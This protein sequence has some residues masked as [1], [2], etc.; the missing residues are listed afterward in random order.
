MV[1][2]NFDG[3]IKVLDDNGKEYTANLVDIL[4][5]PEYPEKSYWLYSFGEE[6]NEQTK[7]YISEYKT[8]D[9]GTSDLLGIKD[10]QEFKKIIDFLNKK[11]TTLA[12]EV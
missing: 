11:V 7:V 2:N 9:D 12:N 6:D 3:K 8:N 10:E 1:V 5:V 4:E